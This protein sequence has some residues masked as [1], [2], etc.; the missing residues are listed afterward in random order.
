MY[1]VCQIITHFTGIDRFWRR[2]KDRVQQNKLTKSDIE[3]PR[4]NVCMSGLWTRS[5]LPSDAEQQR[6][7]E[8]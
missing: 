2:Q 3:P 6:M 5:L 1:G 7:S 4:T 8:I